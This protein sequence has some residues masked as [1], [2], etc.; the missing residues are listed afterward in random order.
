MIHVFTELLEK[1]SYVW[2]SKLIALKQTDVLMTFF[3]DLSEA[4]YAYSCAVQSS[5]PYDFD[6]LYFMISDALKVSRT[7]EDLDRGSASSA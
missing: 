1:S 4:A 3:S 7:D 6:F 5:A 2:F